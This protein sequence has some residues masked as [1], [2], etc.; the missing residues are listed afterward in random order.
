MDLTLCKLRR[1]FYL[2]FLSGMERKFAVIRCLALSPI[3]LS[4]QAVRSD[5]KLRNSIW[6]FWQ[7]MGGKYS[8]SFYTLVSILHLQFGSDL[9]FIIALLQN[10]EIELNWNKTTVGIYSM[11][12]G[13]WNIV[14]KNN[15]SM[16]PKNVYFSLFVVAVRLLSWW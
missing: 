16:K 13:D 15:I 4:V 7:S 12:F 10:Y 5:L 9:L 14:I 1:E 8:F 2:K 11:I 6:L 3:N